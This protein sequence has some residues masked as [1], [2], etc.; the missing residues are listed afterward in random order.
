MNKNKRIIL[1][2]I[3]LIIASISV[4]YFLKGKGYSIGATSEDL[5]TVEVTENKLIKE[6]SNI[7]NVDYAQKLMTQDESSTF[8]SVA[9]AQIRGESVTFLDYKT[10][11]TTTGKTCLENNIM[12]AIISGAG[13][14]NRG[15]KFLYE[16]GAYFSGQQLAIWE[17]WNT[18]VENS[19]AKEIGFEKGAGNGVITE[20]ELNGQTERKKAQEFA[21]QNIYNVNIYFLK[22]FAED[23][24][25]AETKIDNQP[26]LILIEMLDE[27]GDLIEPERPVEENSDIYILS[28]TNAQEITKVGE[29]ISYNINVYNESEEE[30]QNLVLSNKLPKGVT[31]TSVVEIVDDKEKNIDYSYDEKTRKI[32]I[33]INK[34]D[35]STTGTM[36]DE[37]TAE[38]IQYIKTGSKKYKITVKANKLKEG[39]YSKT[40]ENVVEVQKENK[41][42]AR[43]K[44][45]N[46]IS[47][48]FIEII[49]EDL[50]KTLKEAEEFK[51]GFKIINKGLICS[52]NVNVK[53]SAPE[54]IS[55]KKYKIYKSSES[56]EENVVDGT[57]RNNFEREF[58]EIQEQTTIYIQLIGTI[59]EIDETKQITIEGTINDK[60]ITWTTEAQNISNKTTLNERRLLK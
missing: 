32:I 57:I 22:Y 55:L 47:D 28:T 34:I 39:A 54:E 21:A 48:V 9:R 23:N 50:P 37:E 3:L 27:D 41:I 24:K 31:L 13:V 11:N 46:T 53:I 5:F 45:K 14:E 25:D 59:N 2:V 51:L 40:I 52:E 42:F 29:E 60:T 33:E 15:Y 35:G 20:K 10:K 17:F 58:S 38:Q 19:G 4:Y 49:K 16:D 7:Y 12:A 30:Q 36:T 56:G 1:I 26:N 6:Y 44:I 8:K 18:W 43:E